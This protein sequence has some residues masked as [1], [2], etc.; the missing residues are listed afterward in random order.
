MFSVITFSAGALVWFL[1]QPV[2]T[3]LTEL[4]HSDEDSNKYRGETR[5]IKVTQVQ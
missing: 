2:V 3:G 5:V 1:H 4:D